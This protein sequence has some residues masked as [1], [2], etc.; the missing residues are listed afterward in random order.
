M[1]YL[2]IESYVHQDVRI[3][4]KIDYKGKTISLIEVDSDYGRDKIEEKYPP[5]KWVFASREIEYMPAWLEILD[6]MKFAI[7]KAE[8][9]LKEHLDAED[10]AKIDLIMK[11]EK[12][13]AKLFGNPNSKSFGK[14]K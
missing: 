10:K 8:A 2:E 9:K 11:I 3:A 1:K 13:E 4:V 5:K 6:A 7:T 14:K 12:E